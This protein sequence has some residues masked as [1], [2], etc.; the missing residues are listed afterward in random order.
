MT[1]KEK[2]KVKV[3]VRV[4]A[5]NAASLLYLPDSRFYSLLYSLLYSLAATQPT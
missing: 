2:G 5:T 1:R 4:A 3:P